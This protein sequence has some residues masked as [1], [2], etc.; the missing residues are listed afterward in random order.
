[1]IASLTGADFALIVAEPTLSGLHDLERIGDLTAHFNIDTFLVVNKWDVNSR[2]CGHIEELAADRGMQCVGRIRYDLAVTE[3]Q[4][5]GLSVVEHTNNGA[6]ADVRDIW[7]RLAK[8][9]RQ[10]RTSQQLTVL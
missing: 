4:V 9:L 2:I 5:Q 1:V 7:E 10:D 8:P 6:A 3:A